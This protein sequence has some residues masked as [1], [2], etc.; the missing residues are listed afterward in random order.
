MLGTRIFP[1]HILIGFASFVFL[2]CS[3]VGPDHAVP[4]MQLPATFSDGGL[5]WKLHS[6]DT[7]PKP[8][9]WWHLY[10][11]PTLSS[12]VERALSSNQEIAASAARLKQAR[13][14]SKATRQLYFP[15]VNLG[16]DALRSESR[17]GGRSS[18]YVISNSFSVPA[19]MSYELDIWGKVRRQNESVQAAEGAAVES[20][21]ALRLTVASEVAQTYWALRAVDAD[22][23]MLDRTVELRR[24]AVRMITEQRHAGVV[25]G[26]DLSRAET[27]AATVESDRINLDRN[28]ISLVDA[29]AVLCGSAATGSHISEGGDLPKPPNIPISVPSELLRQRPDVRA[30]ERR[31]AASNADIGV[32]TAAYYPSFVINAT[33]GTSASIIEDLFKSTSLVWSIGQNAALPLTRQPYLRAQRDAAVAAHEATSA[34]YRQT[35]LQAIGEVETTLQGTEILTRRLVAQEQAQAAAEKTLEHSTRRFKAGLVTF[36]DVVDAERTRLD[37]ERATNAIRAD[38][39]AVSIALIKAVGGEW[40]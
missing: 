33:G 38:R 3:P 8:R 17:F 21:N 16:A 37:A 12:L 40:R 11:D 2:C 14:I 4:A 27:E 30:A 1:R 32:A 35:V 20:L 18:S 15:E 10:G 19:N 39:L 28:R 5:H 34:D 29:L 26:L 23:A 13:S 7:L 9:E 36:L 24:R 22:R 25:S 31:V 6:P